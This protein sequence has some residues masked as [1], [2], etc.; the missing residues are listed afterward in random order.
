MNFFNN[1]QGHNAV[2]AEGFM[3]KVYGWMAGGLTLTALVSY[4]L[5]P[6]NNPKLFM[7]FFGQGFAPIMLLALV[8][9]G[10]VFY[11][12]SAWQK[13]SY[14]AM[15]F[16]YMTYSVLTGIILTPVVFSYTSASVFSTFA[17]TAAMFSVMA[18]YGWATKSDLSGLQN[19]FFMALIG[20]ILANLFN[21]FFQ[22][23]GFDLVI[24]SIGVGIFS[25][26]VAYDVQK[27]KN[28]SHQL[29]AS[30]E[31]MG[32]VSL[33]GAM[34]LYLDI[35]NLFLYLLRILGKKRR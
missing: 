20:L 5:S 18:L 22:S 9:F 34:M 3:S 27:L 30:P 21:A 26:L 33:L 28:M 6:Y 11:F 23:P 31:D 8:Q 7:L 2:M 12:W 24:A 13:L 16:L 15:A 35:I 10:I 19:I 14:N 1:N 25:M 17:I 29:I 4:M 32:K